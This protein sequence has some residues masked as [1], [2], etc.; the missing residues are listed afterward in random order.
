MSYGTYTNLELL[1]HYG[2]LLEDNPNEK[3]FIPL[4]LDIHCFSSWPKDSLYIHQNGRPSFALMSALRLWA[5]PPYQRK[6]LGHLAY[7]GSQ[8]SQ[9]NEISVMKWIAK[10]CNAILK[11]MP[12]SVE[13]DNMLVSFFDKMEDF[14]NMLEW[15]KTA[16][17]FGGE[18]CKFMK[19]HGLK[20]DD[21]LK[22]SRTKMLID[23]WKLAIQWR[24]IYKK[25]IVRC[26]SHCTDIINTL[27]T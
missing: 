6:S 23:R 5:T 19:A 8:L 7:S 9:G 26:I 13:E 27:S 18:F 10:K 3:V 16:P 24:L 4:E 22:S 14:D 15:G 11:D 25:V 2:F 20:R 17:A 1:E 12:T 21:E